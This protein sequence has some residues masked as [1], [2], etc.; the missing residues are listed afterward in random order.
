MDNEITV[1]P[2]TPQVSVN[3]A[4]GERIIITSVATGDIKTITRTGNDKLHMT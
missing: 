2:G 4:P 1:P 3:L